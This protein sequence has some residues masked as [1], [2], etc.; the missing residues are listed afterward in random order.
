MENASFDKLTPEE[1]EEYLKSFLERTEE[2]RS[3]FFAQCSAAGIV[4]DYS[5]I[6]AMAVIRWATKVCI[7]VPLPV[8]SDVPE[9]IRNSVNFSKDHVALDE[10]SRILTLRI[11][12]YVGECFIRT[13]KGLKWKIGSRKQA[14]AN[15][16]VV[17]G[18]DITEMAV[19]MISQN[20]ITRVI[21]YPEK[22]GD[23][24][25]AFRLWSDRL[26]PQ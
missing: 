22:M 8:T 6:S 4:C 1:A 26:P 16:P 2:S 17:A 18:F 7:A 15:Q 9:W 21:S 12:S 23:I 13:Y 3:E 5:I 24:E 19:L 10:A 20:L 25:V 14:H 11:A